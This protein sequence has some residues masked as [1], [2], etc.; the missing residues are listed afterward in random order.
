MKYKAC[1]VGKNVEG[2]ILICGDKEYACEPHGAHLYIYAKCIDEV[3][4]IRGVYSVTKTEFENKFDCEMSSRVYKGSNNYS[5]GL[6]IFAYD[7]DRI[8]F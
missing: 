2:G 6:Q 8:I 7:P 4:T 5:E 1:G 3:L